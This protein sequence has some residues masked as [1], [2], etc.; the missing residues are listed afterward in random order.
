DRVRVAAQ[1]ATGLTAEDLAARLELLVQ[2]VTEELADPDQDP[3]V[4]PVA[5]GH[6]LLAQMAADQPTLHAVVRQGE[7]FFTRQQRRRDGRIHGS[8]SLSRSTAAFHPE[9]VRYCTPGN[10]PGEGRSPAHQTHPLGVV[11]SSRALRNRPV[12]KLAKAAAAAGGA[13]WGAG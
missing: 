1:T 12:G 10:R 4:L 6:G 3:A 8:H 2:P 5:D 9:G 7:E 11:R 13:V